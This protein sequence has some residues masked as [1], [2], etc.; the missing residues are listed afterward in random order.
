MSIRVLHVVEDFSSGNTG[1]TS[2]VRQIAQWQAKS[3]E[4][5]GVYTVGPIDL[6][7]PDRV[8]VEIADQD[9]FS[10]SWRY[11]ADGLAGLLRVIHENRVT[12]LHLHGLWRAAS[13]LGVKAGVVSGVPMVL[14]VHGQTSPWAL[15]G[16]G[17]LKHLK[18]WLYWHCFARRQFEKVKALHAITS[19]EGEHIA[20]FFKRRDFVVIPNAIDLD[21]KEQGFSAAIEPTRSFVFL[22]R[23]HPVKG[24]DI[25]IEAFSTADL[26]GEDWRLVLAGPEEVPEYVQHLRELAGR[27]SRGAQIDFVGPVFKQEKQSLLKQAWALVAPSH[28]EVIGMVNLE[29][30]AQKTP[31]LTTHQTGL[32]DWQDGGGVLTTPEVGAL[33]T[34]L[35]KASCWSME[36]R[37]Q[38]GQASYE[39]VQR[40]Y[41]QR[42]VGPLW[43]DL[44]KKLQVGGA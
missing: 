6:P 11:P 29:A 25:L 26:R 32:T 16:Q 24:V 34:A 8:H 40:R 28:T 14:S 12:V 17:V 23:L 4:W 5:V 38:R 30:A 42:A 27:S 41:S 35:E 43:I 18:K 13:F 19:L 36:E 2:V 31:S 10:R 1:V 22:G 9:Q 3:C 37:L 44:Y 15:N 39:L 7:P 20:R 21:S 33:R